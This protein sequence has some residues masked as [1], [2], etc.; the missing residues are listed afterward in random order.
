MQAASTAH[1]KVSQLT[2]AEHKKNKKQR[3]M[4]EKYRKN[5]REWNEVAAEA[6]RKLL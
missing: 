5:K 3:E 6:K 4:L 2:L 1:S